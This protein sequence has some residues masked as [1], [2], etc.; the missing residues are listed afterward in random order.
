[1]L[2][3]VLREATAQTKG[4]GAA[5]FD[6]IAIEHLM[7]GLA[8][9]YAVEGK[10]DK[11]L[12]VYLEQLS[13]GSGSSTGQPPRARN[14]DTSHIVTLIQEHNLLHLVQDKLLLVAQAD[15]TRALKLF[16]EHAAEVCR[17]ASV[18]CVLMLE[19][20]CAGLAGAVEVRCPSAYGTPGAVAVIF[21]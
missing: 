18:F 13:A 6:D 11:S 5:Q 12:S 16:V 15:P 1:M 21:E 14:R 7:D 17:H 2:Q 3:L 8:E 20:C 10:F 9:L 19:Q 4:S